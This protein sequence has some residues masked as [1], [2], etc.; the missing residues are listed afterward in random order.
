MTKNKKI[1][2]NFDYDKK[3]AKSFHKTDYY[4]YEQ[5]RIKTLFQKELDKED[6]KTH[7]KKPVS[8]IIEKYVEMGKNQEIKV[9]S[10]LEKIRDKNI[11]NTK[12][13][14]ND[15]MNIVS[16]SFILLTAYRTIRK[17]KGALTEASNLPSFIYENLKEEQKDLYN[18]TIGMPDGMTWDIIDYIS[19][20]LKRNTYPPLWGMG[21]ITFLFLQ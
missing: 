11:S 2:A 19:F 13:K 17:K 9:F 4:E 3:I 18:K 20:H 15:I 10:I 5:D 7:F 12:S 16:N 21:C 8:Y 1:Y 14:N 6:L